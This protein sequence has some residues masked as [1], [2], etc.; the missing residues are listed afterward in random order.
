MLI[1]PPTCWGRKSGNRDVRRNPPKPICLSSVR[2]SNLYKPN[3][4]LALNCSVI[5]STL[6]YITEYLP[7]PSS[8]GS[9]SRPL[10]DSCKDRLPLITS[11]ISC[12]IGGGGGGEDTAIPQSSTCTLALLSLVLSVTNYA[13]TTFQWSPFSSFVPKFVERRAGLRKEKT[14]QNL[15]NC[16]PIN[17]FY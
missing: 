9:A 13:K 5:D 3:K 10:G 2:A 15:K 8:L 12:E 11:G 6:R 17:I 14:W 4:W 16:N 1:N 7:V